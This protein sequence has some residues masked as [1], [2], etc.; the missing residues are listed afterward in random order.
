MAGAVA[1]YDTFW[2][3]VGGRRF[4]LTVGSGVINTALLWFDK[5]D[6]TTFRDIILGT[7]GA[8]IVANTWQKYKEIR[9]D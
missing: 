3:W 6:K 7:V 2:R 5:L 9:S 8:Y 1:G 4:L